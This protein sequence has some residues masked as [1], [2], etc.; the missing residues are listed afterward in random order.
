MKKTLAIALC[1]LLIGAVG[2]YL[3]LK[4]L[5]PRWNRSAENNTY[6]Q[7]TAKLDQGGEAFGYLHTEKITAAVQHIATGL[8]K[9]LPAAGGQDKTAQ[10]FAMLNMLFKGYGLEEIS[11]LGFSSITLRPGLH[12]NRVVIHHRPGRDKG[13]IWNISGPAPRRLDELDMLAADTAL[14]F[15]ADYNLEKLAD[16]IGKQGQQMPG[17]QVGP[18]LN[19]M[20]AGLASAGIDSD[21]LFKSYGGRLGFLLTLD[22]EKRVVLPVRGASISIPEP[23][24]AILIQV[25]DNYLFDLIK[26]KLPPSGQAQFK[27]EA[28]IRKIGFPRLPTPFPFEPTIAQKGKWLIAASL[29]SVVQGVFGDQGGRLGDSDDFKAL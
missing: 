4:V 13:L 23:G 17:Q 26:S 25:N 8:E 16:W 18:G 27:D 1:A 28:G 2:S 20:K 3:V 15:V 7:V 12:R 14:A 11:G 29:G 5:I 6:W 24:I 10:T 9:N 22:P 21:R 19:M